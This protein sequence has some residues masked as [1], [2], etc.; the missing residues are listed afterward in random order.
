MSKRSKRRD[1][2]RKGLTEKQLIDLHNYM[3]SQE[4]LIIRI[5]VCKENIEWFESLAD[6]VKLELSEG[7]LLAYLDKPKG[8]TASPTD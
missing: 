7:H 4:P 8:H 3:Q 1:R 5:P 6:E 2:H